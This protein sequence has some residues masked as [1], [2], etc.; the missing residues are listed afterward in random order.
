MVK[1]NLSFYMGENY[2]S[3]NK[4][5]LRAAAMAQMIEHLPNS[6]RP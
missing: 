6:V 4:R 2:V 5:V 1:F 3:A